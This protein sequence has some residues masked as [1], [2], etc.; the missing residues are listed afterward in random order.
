MFLKVGSV[1][2]K[3]APKHLQK[4]ITT[5]LTR[6]LEVWLAKFLKTTTVDKPNKIIVYA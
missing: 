1:G 6:W 2:V 3:E 5:Y 4:S